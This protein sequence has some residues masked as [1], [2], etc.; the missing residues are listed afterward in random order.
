MPTQQLYLPFKELRIELHFQDQLVKGSN[1]FRTL[2][3]F[4]EFLNDN[5]EIKK[6]LQTGD[7]DNG[8]VISKDQDMDLEN[9]I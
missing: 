3:E 5:P 8:I 7:L 9:R 1:S 6:A 4:A 2:K